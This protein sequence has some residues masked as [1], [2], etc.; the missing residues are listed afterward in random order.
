MEEMVHILLPVLLFLNRNWGGMELS[1][2][3]RGY[4]LKKEAP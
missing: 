3:M 1:A 4:H 2:M